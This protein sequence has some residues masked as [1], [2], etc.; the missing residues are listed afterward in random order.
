MRELSKL[1]HL[2]Q[3]LDGVVA[4]AE[5]PLVGECV[6]GGVARP[7]HRG[8]LVQRPVRLAQVALLEEVMFAGRPKMVPR[9]R[10]HPL[11]HLALIGR[12][13]LHNVTPRLRHRTLY[14]FN[15]LAVHVHNQLARVLIFIVIV[16]R[17]ELAVFEGA[18]PPAQ[19]LVDILGHTILLHVRQYTLYREVEHIATISA[20]SSKTFRYLRRQ[21]NL[22]ARLLLLTAHVVMTCRSPKLGILKLASWAPEGFNVP[23]IPQWRRPLA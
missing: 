2:Q 11:A 8:D 21:Q 3:A 16:E 19:C 1:F 6:D 23:D 12:Q 7:A 5:G 22:L 20:V 18:A 15:Q 9:Q 14:T 13:V 4:L 10:R 17:F